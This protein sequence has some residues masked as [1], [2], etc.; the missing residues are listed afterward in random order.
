VIE[1][2]EPG[3]HGY[4]INYSITY[5]WDGLHGVVGASNMTG[6]KIHVIVLLMTPIREFIDMNNHKLNKRHAVLG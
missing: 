2:L 1:S 6:W 4:C 3:K 5:H